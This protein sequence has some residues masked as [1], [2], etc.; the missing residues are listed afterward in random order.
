M[1]FIPAIISFAISAC[2]PTPANIKRAADIIARAIGYLTLIKASADIIIPKAVEILQ[3][4]LM[5]LPQ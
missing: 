5:S 1:S 3:A 2:K 4:V